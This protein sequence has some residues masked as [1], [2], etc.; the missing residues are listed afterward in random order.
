VEQVAR[1]KRKVAVRV[2]ID[3]TDSGFGAWVNMCHSGVVGVLFNGRQVHDVITADEELGYLLKF[4]LDEVGQPI[5]HGDQWLT[6]EL[7]GTVKITNAAETPPPKPKT[8][9][10]KGVHVKPSELRTALLWTLLAVAVGVA[11]L[12]M[13]VP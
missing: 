2:S 6:E 1:A 12:V 8:M 4:K 5:A 9:A 10:T 7:T 3:K 13:V 11:V